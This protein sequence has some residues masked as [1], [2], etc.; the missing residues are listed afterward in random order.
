ML[1]MNT[2]DTGA[3]KQIIFYTVIMILFRLRLFYRATGD[4]LYLSSNCYNR[5]FTGLFNAVLCSATL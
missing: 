3:V 1:P 2:K 5:C 4:F